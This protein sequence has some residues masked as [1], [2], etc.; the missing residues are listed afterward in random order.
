[1][2]KKETTQEQ[3]AA[4]EDQQALENFNWDP[5]GSKDFF[6]IKD[7]AVETEEQVI[8]KVKKP[9]ETA[10]AEV[11]EEVEETEEEKTARLKEEE[12]INASEFFK[13]EK[14]GDGDGDEEGTTAEIGEDYYKNLTKTLKE[15]GIFEN[16]EI[17][18]DE[19]IDEDKFFELHDEEIEARVEGAL[20]GFMDELDEDGKGFLKFKKEGGDTKEFFN[21]YRG[22]SK[23]P[24]GDLDDEAF[25]EKISRYYYTNIEDLDIED[26]DERIEWLKSSGKL[27][28]YSEKQQ[29][30]I[31]ALETKAKED[32]QKQVKLK[33]KVQEEARRKFVSTV[34]ET[35]E[36]T[37]KV[38][39]FVFNPKEKRK[40]HAF[41]TKPTVKVGKNQYLTG[42]QDKLS[43]VLKDPKKML[44][45]AK[46]LNNDFD[47]SDVVAATT[48][49][50]TKKI[51]KKIQR[52]KIT[53]PVTSGKSQRKK[54]LADFF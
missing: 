19:E 30:K 46:L 13:D 26:V 44:L 34:K 6:G 5:D 10:A 35:L 47:V 42:M 7:T 54:N 43:K 20:E 50:N 9:A 22:F 52:A 2:A 15:K 16:I 24:T 41:I 37:E 12:K 33:A 32:L 14:D 1:M 8:E 48:T 17:P 11:E 39:N 49:E 27:E 36:N 23:A 45:L 38:D 40:L 51:K 28:K 25:Q 31:H 3:E 4:T 29:V 21:V 18:E 53:K